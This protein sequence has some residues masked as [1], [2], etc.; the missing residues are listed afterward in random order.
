MCIAGS[1]GRDASNGRDDVVT[2]QLL[3]NLNAERMGVQGPLVTD[4]RAG[5]HTIAAIESFQRQ[6]V[7]MRNPDGRVE[8]NRSTLAHLRAGLR[9]G[10]CAAKLHGVVIRATPV[11]LATY[12]G[13]LAAR[14]A[15]HG[16]DTPLRMAHFL[17]QIAHESGD[18]RY[19]EEL[20]SGAQYEGR[21]D[22]GNR[23]P[24]DGRR[25]KGRGLIQLTGRANYARYGAARRCDFTTAAGARALAT[26]PELAVDVACWFWHDRGLNAVADTDDLAAV[27]RMINGGVV[28]LAQRRAKLDRARFFFVALRCP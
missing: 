13:P 21:A 12:A 5:R 16:I 9:P 28:G 6:V 24:G 4:G 3:L 15:V 18:L 10:F 14:M 25:F 7:K 23:R 2:V 17:A 22:L 20:G 26:D 19:V 11:G 8:P 27:T 1:V